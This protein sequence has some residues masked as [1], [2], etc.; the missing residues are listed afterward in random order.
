MGLGVGLGLGLCPVGENSHQIHE[1]RQKR[2]PKIHSTTKGPPSK[3]S[4][5][6]IETVEL[7]RPN[8]E[9]LLILLIIIVGSN[10]TDGIF[11]T[12]RPRHLE[13]FTRANHGRARI[14][15]F[16]P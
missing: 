13:R 9:G 15:R 2:L 4:Q 14:P 5:P 16:S 1:N 12:R 3:A 10:L 11:I 8:Q 7:A 6:K